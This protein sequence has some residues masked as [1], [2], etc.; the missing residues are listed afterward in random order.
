MTLR[1][2][3]PPCPTA[4]RTP[5]E[6]RTVRT[7]GRTAALSSG[8]YRRCFGFLRA[9]FVLVER[10]HVQCRQPPKLC[11][12]LGGVDTSCEPLALPIRHLAAPALLLRVH[13]FDAFFVGGANARRVNRI[14]GLAI[15]LSR[16]QPSS[17][18]NNGPGPGE[19]QLPR[20]HLL[21][22]TTS[23]PSTIY[24]QPIY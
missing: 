13:G 1:S 15:C 9:S 6:E 20:G 8:L 18:G 14:A 17:S 4:R 23:Y 7:M 24:C 16:L 21:L 19:W 22:P 5:S 11:P 3:A 12:V 2:K 10:L